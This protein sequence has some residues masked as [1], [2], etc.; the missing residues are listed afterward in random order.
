MFLGA[1]DNVRQHADHLPFRINN[2]QEVSAADP[3]IHMEPIAW[4]E[5]HQMPFQ[6]LPIANV[7]LLL[8]HHQLSLYIFH[9]LL[10]MLQAASS[11]SHNGVKLV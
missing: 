7:S 8:I 2:L 3:R 11:V 1:L 9:H 10:I 4:L 5:R 6:T